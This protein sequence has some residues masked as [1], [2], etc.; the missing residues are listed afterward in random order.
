MRLYQ[1]QLEAA[2]CKIACTQ[3]IVDQGKHL[4]KEAKKAVKVRSMVRKCR[5]A[6]LSGAREETGEGS[7]GT[8]GHD[9]LLLAC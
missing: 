9:M 3:D 5:K 1:I 4:R 2:R 8:Q 6:V 7:K